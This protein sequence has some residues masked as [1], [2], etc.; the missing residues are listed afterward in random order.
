MMQLNAEHLFN[1]MVEIQNFVISN[2]KQNS[3]FKIESASS[4]VSSPVASLQSEKNFRFPVGLKDRN[5]TPFSKAFSL[6][7]KLNACSKG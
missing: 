4:S 3:S 2:E 5:L 6:K 7:V 1:S